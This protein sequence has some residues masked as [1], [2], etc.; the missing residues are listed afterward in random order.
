MPGGSGQEQ[1]RNECVWRVGGS[2]LRR[3]AGPIGEELAAS[4]KEL[5]WLKQLL[6]KCLLN[7]NIGY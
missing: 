5:A 1:V 2:R 6:D 4:S 7:W 3:Q